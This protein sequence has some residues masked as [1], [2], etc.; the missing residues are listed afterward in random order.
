[1]PV[2]AV[3]CFPAIKGSQFRVYHPLIQVLN[4]C[5]VLK[6]LGIFYFDFGFLIIVK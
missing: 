1:M 4:Q 6:G 2:S 5:D 3:V